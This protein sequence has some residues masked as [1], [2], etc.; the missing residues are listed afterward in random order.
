MSSPRL[1]RWA[2][3]SYAALLGLLPAAQAARLSLFGMHPGRERALAE[4]AEAINLDR[5]LAT[6]REL[7]A[8]AEQLHERA[9]D[10]LAG[11]LV[12][13]LATVPAHCRGRAALFG[14]G[15]EL[16]RA[17]LVRAGLPA[18][19]IVMAADVM[20]PELAVIASV[21]GAAHAAAELALD[22]RLPADL[23]R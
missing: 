21:Y 10:R 15:V 14:L 12:R 6:D 17:A 22:Q 18:D 8:V 19:G 5:E 9:V 16:A 4:L 3:R 20:D 13:A 23:R 2:C 1:F 7:Q 11:E